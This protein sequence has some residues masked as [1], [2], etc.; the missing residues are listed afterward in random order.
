MLFGI[1]VLS[2]SCR[3][4]IDYIHTVTFIYKN[5]TAFDLVME[6][7]NMEG[8]NFRNFPITPNEQV[9][10]NISREEGPA[11]FLFYEPIDKSGDSVVIRFS[12][13]RCL[14]YSRNSGFGRYGDKIFDYR[15]YD[16]YSPDLVKQRKPNVHY[17]LYYT[18]T[19]EDYNQSV[20]CE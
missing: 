15:E 1:S 16:N 11:P 7:Y 12:N 8:V 20:N 19:V 4:H 9:V 2:N 13:N 17:R 3:K 6:V 10:T 18:I 5:G 14:S